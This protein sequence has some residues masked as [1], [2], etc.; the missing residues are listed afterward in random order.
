MRIVDLFCLQPFDKEWEMI[1]NF[2]SVEDSVDHMTAKKSH[3]NLVSCVRIN[4]R[5]LMNGFKDV[6]C[7]RPVRKF[8]IIES[9]LVDCQLVPTLEIFYW[10]IFEDYIHLTVSI[11]KHEMS[12]HIFLL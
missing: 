10:H 7:C 12:F 4:F 5:V 8:Q 6:G 1:V 2:L 3:L 9:F 11:L